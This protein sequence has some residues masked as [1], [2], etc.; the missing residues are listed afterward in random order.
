MSMA[1]GSIDLDK[2][3]PGPADLHPPKQA[4]PAHEGEEVIDLANL[5]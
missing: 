1:G 3:G 5:R 2:L 4:T